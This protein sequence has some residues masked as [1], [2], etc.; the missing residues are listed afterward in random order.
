MGIKAAVFIAAISKID[1]ID[2]TFFGHRTLGGVIS[3][4]LSKRS[5]MTFTLA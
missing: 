2:R 1:I 4:S 5:K 3:L